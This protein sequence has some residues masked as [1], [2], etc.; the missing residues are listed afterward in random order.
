MARYIVRRLFYMLPVTLVLSFVC[1]LVVDLAPGDFVSV[2]ESSI[3]SNLNM[4]EQQK[5][6]ALSSLGE[7]RV[8]YGLDR[9]VL[10][11]YAVWVFNIV[12]RGDFGYS[13][14]VAR[15]V[16]TLILERMGWTVLMSLLGLVV[17]LTASFALG[18][19]SARHQYS[20][21]DYVTN[22]V[23][24]L[25]MATPGFFLALI[26]MTVMVFVFNEQVGGLFSSDYVNAPW[27]WGKLIDLL[28]HLSIPLGVGLVTGA[29]AGMRI[30]RGNLL[31]KLNQPYVQTARAKGLPENLVVY[32]H[33]LR[34]ALHPWVMGMSNTL[35]DLISGD[36]ILSI[37]LGLPTVGLMFYDALTH[38]DS[39]VAGTFLLMATL[40]L[41]VGTL[42]ADIVLAWLD[43]TVRF[44]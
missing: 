20:L 38:Q 9:P 7:L 6:V 15:P 25:G 27:S 16:H 8:Q 17:G 13:F 28:K 42:L 10:A 22:I 26:F 31:D 43:P 1:F 23:A 2:Y 24:F 40:L 32:R 18:I 12:T 33:A 36:T 3:R 4:S 44:E 30:I 19:Y 41:Q 5:K 35:S 21:F 11:R 34:N 14:Q 29:G 39:Y 37:V